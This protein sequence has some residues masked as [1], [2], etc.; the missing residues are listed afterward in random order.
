MFN[1]CILPGDSDYISVKHYFQN[2]FGHAQLHFNT[3]DTQI[4]S[5]ISAPLVCSLDEWA[6]KRS[7]AL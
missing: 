1:M 7:I 6:I 2:G 3:A 5:T 4:T